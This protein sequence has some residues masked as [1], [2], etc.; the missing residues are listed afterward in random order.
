LTSLGALPQTALGS[1][2]RFPDFLAGFKGPASNGR[3]GAKG[4]EEG[5]G[6]GRGE[7]S[8]VMSP[9]P[10]RTKFA[11]AY[12]GAEVRERRGQAREQWRI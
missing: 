10:I 9:P 6:R 1:L 2:Q 12:G 5:K 8:R 4:R 11:R 3:G 7:K